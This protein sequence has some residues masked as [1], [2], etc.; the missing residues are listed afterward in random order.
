MT[1][2]PS[3]ELIN[4]TID[5]ILSRP[6][7]Q[8]RGKGISDYIL[9]KL[10]DLLGMLFDAAGGAYGIPVA[11]LIGLAA[12]LILL[13]VILVLRMKRMRRL[14]SEK[15]GPPKQMYG[16]S[17]LWQAAIGFAG[18]GEFNK[19]LICLFLAHLRLLDEYGLITI[20]K[21]KTNI[22]YEQELIQNGYDGI[23]QF[24]EFKNLF[25]AVRYGYLNVDGNTFSAWQE[26]CLK[27]PLKE[28]AA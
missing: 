6:E 12:F 25:N 10:A 5:G 11:V 27:P 23:Q 20:E 21:S 7:F 18:R 3:D 1:E 14:D 2:F 4:S 26:Y 19:A 28:D 24:R 22:Q 15:N 13:T 9:E 16:G 8:P 17:E